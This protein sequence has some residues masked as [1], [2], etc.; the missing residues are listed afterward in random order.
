MEGIVAT[1][2][3]TAPEAPEASGDGRLPGYY[4][5]KGSLAMAA[6]SSASD[7]LP[8]GLGHSSYGLATAPVNEALS[9]ERFSVDRS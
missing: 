9:G 8:K 3:D 7:P 4:K 1:I 6:A 2:S 5:G